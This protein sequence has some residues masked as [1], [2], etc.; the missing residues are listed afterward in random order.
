AIHLGVAFD[1]GAGIAGD[2]H[3]GARRAGNDADAA[4]RTVVRPEGGRRPQAR[5]DRHARETRRRVRVRREGMT[6]FRL[7]YAETPNPRKACVVAKHLG[8][9]VEFVHVELGKGEHKA[10]AFTAL[11]PNQKVP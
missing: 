5:L 7:Y 1:A 10:P 9:P 11:N 4:A 6:D 8:S 3:A 2:D